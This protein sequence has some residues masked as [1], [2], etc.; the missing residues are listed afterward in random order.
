MK[1]P[2]EHIDKLCTT[3][4]PYTSEKDAEFKIKAMRKKGRIITPTLNI[5]KCRFCPAWHIGHI[6]TID[7]KGNPV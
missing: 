6:R 4:H 7:K 3:K 1:I 2:Q 5:Y